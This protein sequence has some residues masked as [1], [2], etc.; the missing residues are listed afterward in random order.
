[1]FI[2]GEDIESDREVRK[3]KSRAK[4]TRS[5]TGDSRTKKKPQ[6]TKG[7]LDSS[8]PDKSSFA[9]S[10]SVPEV[11]KDG[12]K[13]K[14]MDFVK[15]FSQGASVGAGGDS[16]EQS[17]RWRAKEPP[18]TDINQDGSNVKE[19]VNIPDQQKKPTPDIPAVVLNRKIKILLYVP[20]FMIPPYM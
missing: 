12:A 1:M 8:I 16:L 3:G 17:S 4:N 19:T 14:V 9:S 6:N 18:K 13:G 5:S 15:I 20:W 7:S 10:S 11:G 2:A